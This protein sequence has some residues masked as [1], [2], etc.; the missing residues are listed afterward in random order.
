VLPGR[1][2]QNESLAHRD[3]KVIRNANC[4]VRL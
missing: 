2:P 1:I 4:M 3:Q